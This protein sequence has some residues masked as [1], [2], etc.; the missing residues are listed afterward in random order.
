MDP[1]E[2]VQ[3][4][5]GMLVIVT[6]VLAT[7]SWVSYLLPIAIRNFG[8]T[9]RALGSNLPPPTRWLLAAPQVWLVFVVLAVPLFIW[10]IARSRV[11]REELG[12]MKFA[13]GALIVAML[14]A[15]GIAAWAIYIP[16]ARQAEV[17]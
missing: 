14:L 11:T 8:D 1:R 2:E 3:R 16:F 9:F 5:G 17:I 15:Y 10:V 13:M 12:R 4:P 6:L 7:A